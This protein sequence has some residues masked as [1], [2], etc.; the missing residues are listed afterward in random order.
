MPS[1]SKIKGSYHERVIMNW[2]NES[3]IETKKQPLS[4]ALGG[5]YSGDLVI[6][7]PRLVVEVKYRD[8]NSFPSPFTV[9]KNRDLAIYKRREGDPKMIVVMTTETFLKLM[10]SH[11]GKSE[12]SNP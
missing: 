5:E 6:Q 12:Q 11:N 3:G 4:G 7:S 9:L 10:E 2:L 8:G 1:K